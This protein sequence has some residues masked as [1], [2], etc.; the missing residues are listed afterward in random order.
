MLNLPAKL[1]FMLYRAGVCLGF[2]VVCV[3]GGVFLVV[4]GFNIE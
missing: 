2:E 4:W 3:L 1:F